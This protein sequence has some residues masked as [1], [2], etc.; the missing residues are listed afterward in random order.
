MKN[1]LK[2]A[3]KEK[4]IKH[5]LHFTKMENLD[6]ILK[7][8][9]I[10]RTELEESGINHVTNDSYRYD[11]QESAICCSIGH[12]NYKMFYALRQQDTSVPWVV[13][14]IKRVVLWSKKCA[15]C[16]TNAGNNTVSSIPID[17][18][19][20]FN[21]FMAMFSEQ[22]HVPS[23]T[24]LGIP[25]RCPT[26]PQ[27]EVL[28]LEPI[29]PKYILAVLTSTDRVAIELREKYPEFRFEYIRTAFSYRKDYT[30]W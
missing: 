22:E 21:P 7:N 14:A 4:E 23:R 13:I 26:D 25:D 24:K 20:G 30:H 3:V 19:I 28:V 5:L 2:T 17:D 10:G 1:N 15:F 29:Q 9:L 12:P 18:R 8:G 16:T 27:A 11:Q 6:S